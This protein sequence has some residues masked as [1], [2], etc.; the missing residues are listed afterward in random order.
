MATTYM[1][2]MAHHIAKKEGCNMHHNAEEENSDWTTDR[3]RPQHLY[4]KGTTSRSMPPLMSGRG[5][6]KEKRDDMIE[7]DVSIDPLRVKSMPE[8]VVKKRKDDSEEEDSGAQCGSREPSHPIPS[9]H[10]DP[11]GSGGGEEEMVI[12]GQVVCANIEGVKKIFRTLSAG[13]PSWDPG[14]DI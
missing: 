6:R 1:V 11:R 14:I 13:D 4:S 8:R 2:C 10:R 5:V 3:L 12:E 9:H 7:C